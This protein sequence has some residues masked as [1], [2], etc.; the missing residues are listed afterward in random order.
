MVDAPRHIIQPGCAAVVQMT[1]H[2]VRY[3]VWMLYLPPGQA[4]DILQAILKYMRAKGQ[5]W[6][7]AHTH[8][9]MGDTNFGERPEPGV[10]PSKTLRLW[11]DIQHEMGAYEVEQDTA[12]P[13]SYAPTFHR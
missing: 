3:A 7:D 1:K 11:M 9:L 10:S 5:P 8:I 12:Q 13:G 6:M 4:H 2:A